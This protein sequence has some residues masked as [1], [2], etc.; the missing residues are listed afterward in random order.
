MARTHVRTEGSVLDTLTSWMVPKLS[1]AVATMLKVVTLA[2]G[3]DAG[4]AGGRMNVFVT[5]AVTFP[6][7]GGHT[8]QQ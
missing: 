4:S 5:S 3:L 7:A 6:A 2:S 1:V 8:V